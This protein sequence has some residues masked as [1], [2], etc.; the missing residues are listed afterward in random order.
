MTLKILLAEVQ[1]FSSAARCLLAEHAELVQ[2]GPSRRELLASA[3]D[4][5]ILW[6]RLAHV[7]DAE[8]IRAAPKLRVVASNTTGLNHI[9]VETLAERQIKLLSLKGE[10]EFLQDVRATA[11]HTLAL[12]LALIRRI[13][14]AYSDV[15]KG[16][17]RREDFQGR[18]LFGKTA[19][20]IGYGRLGRLVARYLATL[21]MN[22]VVSE[23]SSSFPQLDSGIRRVSTEELLQIADVVSL[24][25]DFSPE[26]ERML[27]HAEFAL[28]KPDAIFVNTA[29]GELID[30]IALVN[31]LESG[32]IGGAAL[33]VLSDE[34]QSISTSNRLIVYAQSHE[35][36]IISPHIG[37]FTRESLEKTEVF[38]AKKICEWIRGN[39]SDTTGKRMCP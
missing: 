17:W 27:S 34:H 38:I 12:I 31:A 8:V 29:R 39:L 28:M 19:G 35:N 6:V 2:C 20:I 23:K 11:E 1:C 5:D 25:A 33:D 9:D 30:E 4:I 32:R 36:L 7:V 14:A 16:N 22:I 3:S 15:L 13:P 18:E 24:H 21:G 37:G 26:N 10:T